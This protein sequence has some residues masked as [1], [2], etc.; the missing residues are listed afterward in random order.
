MC[1][2]VRVIFMCLCKAWMI[3]GFC[4]SSLNLSN[5]NGVFLEGDCNWNKFNTCLSKPLTLYLKLSLVQVVYYIVHILIQFSKL[6]HTSVS[7]AVRLK[8]LAH[9]WN[10]GSCCIGSIHKSN[11]GSRCILVIGI[12]MIGLAIVEESQIACTKASIYLFIYL[13]LLGIFIDSYS[14]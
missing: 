2:I 5:L 6:R 4:A 3:N 1:F 10:I 9:R 13:L 12:L 14:N 7:A 11:I 8:F